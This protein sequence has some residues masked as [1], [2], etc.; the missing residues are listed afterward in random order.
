VHPDLLALDNLGA[1]NVF[2]QAA[3]V[4]GAGTTIELDTPYHAPDGRTYES[5]TAVELDLLTDAVAAGYHDTGIRAKDPVA[6]YVTESVRY[7]VNYV[8]L[9]KIGAIPVFLNSSLDPDV[10]ALFIAKV[11]AAAVVSEE[12]R[13]PIHRLGIAYYDAEPYSTATRGP[14]AHVAEDPVLIAHTSGT[15]GLPKAVQFNH[16][17]FFYGI[18]QQLGADLGERVLSALPQ[19]HGSA[20]S[21][22]MSVVA[23]GVDAYLATD[24]D[25]ERLAGT[26]ERY[27]PQ[28][29]AAFPRVFVDLCRVDLDSYD[30]GSVGRWLS[31]GDANHERHI[32]TLVGYGSHLDR[33]GQR[34]PGSLFIDNF[35]SSEFGFAM[36]RRVYSSTSQDY[37]RCIGRPFD[38]AQAEIF[39]E[40]DE[41]VAPLA[42]GRLAV[43][44]PTVTAGYWN[45]TRLS[46][47]NRVHG[48][49]LT[50]DLAYR[51]EAG[52]YYH[53]DR[54]SDRIVTAT[55]TL[56]STQ[57]EELILRR[58]PEVF[59]C[60]LVGVGEPG[61][62]PVPVLTAE[63]RG[64]TADL[65]ERINQVLTA[66]GLP[67][68]GRLVPSAEGERL[69]I[70]GQALKRAMRLSL[71]GRA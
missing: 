59:D 44:S 68:I 60:S 14:Y 63:V 25:P 55:S 64:E 65:L 38:W 34:Q 7:L 69:G 41:P 19:S 29:V 1:G 48:Y 52:R 35:G 37:R 53:V 66:E 32:R 46:E 62:T 21:I 5:L 40:E 10:A 45:N 43:R 27:R 50:G 9:T 39:D 18:R 70:T 58:F 23:R 8:A 54:T 31:T 30:L 71:A 11:E 15:T 61:T 26:I 47:R 49:W 57:T 13:L 28:L 4:P 12:T 3:R 24:R 33:A 20:I 42:V 2:W 36:F 16:A 67:P 17:G 6:V 51:D 56:Y 22:L